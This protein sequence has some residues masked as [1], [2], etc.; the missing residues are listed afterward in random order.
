MYFLFYTYFYEH[1]VTSKVKHGTSIA[2]YR[3]I[4]VT[5]K[6][7]CAPP[8]SPTPRTPGLGPLHPSS[9]KINLNYFD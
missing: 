8:F 1:F 5:F 3:P 4:I 7:I 9:R 6:G 2:A